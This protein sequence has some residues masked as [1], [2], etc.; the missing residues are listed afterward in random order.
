VSFNNAFRGTRVLITGHTGFKGTWLT[1]WLAE[2]GA[3]VAGFSV[4]IPT[5]PA[6][7]EILGLEGVVDH[8]LGDVRNLAEVQKALDDFAPQVVFHLAAQ[9]LVRRSYEDPV[10]TFAVNTLGTAH[11]LEAVRQSPCVS[12]AVMITSDKCYRNLEW[13]WGYRENDLL[14]GED[15]YS[16][17]KGAAE[18]VFHSYSQSYFGSSDGTRVASARA[19]NVI[20]GGDW[21]EDRL[22]PDCVRSWSEGAIV[23][24]R[25]PTATRPWQHVLEPLSGY[26]SLAASL[27]DGPE[28]HG[29]SY[30]FGPA[31]SANESVGKLVEEVGRFW[32]AA[33]WRVDPSGAEDR[34]EAR[35]LKLSCDKSLADLDWTA[36]LSFSETVRFTAEWYEAYYG[37]GGPGMLDL[38]RGQIG[39]F[40]E[41]AKNRGL[42]WS[43][44]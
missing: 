26:L 22:I 39:E 2:L 31:A 10:G 27:L 13:E 41:L 32:P 30:N 16:G 8:R 21:A 43:M 3:E 11:V 38:T 28:C 19:G 7:F 44:P 23:T 12:A 40:T 18:L 24:L 37:R 34:P 25:H 33:R 15:P 36:T 14:G 42:P 17:S 35:L 1:A 20:G 29:Q 9:A 6:G 4:D 5:Q